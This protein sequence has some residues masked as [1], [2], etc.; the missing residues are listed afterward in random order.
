MQK[1][2]LTFAL[3]T[4][5]VVV[6]VAVLSHFNNNSSTYL[7]ENIYLGNKK[8]Q[9]SGTDKDVDQFLDI[10]FKFHKTP[11]SSDAKTA[12]PVLRSKTLG[13]CPD[14]PPNLVGPLRIEFNRSHTWNTVRKEVTV[15]LQD[16]GRY[17]PRECFSEHK[18]GE[19]GKQWTEMKKLHTH[20]SDVSMKRINVSEVSGNFCT[21]GS[22]EQSIFL[23][24][25]LFI[26]RIFIQ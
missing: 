26:E 12:K 25:L 1:N 20:Y 15:P 9:P 22:N 11:E 2:L 17:V 14:T 8:D 18:V 13:P 19:T 16:G 10:N 7:T 23:E 21:E 24:F 6:C 5:V 4:I 3:L